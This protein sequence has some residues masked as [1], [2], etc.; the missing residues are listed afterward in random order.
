MATPDIVA[1]RAGQPDGGARHVLGPG[2]SSLGDAGQDA[3]M[4]SGDFLPCLHRQLGIEP[5]V[6]AIED[7]DRLV[8]GRESEIVRFGTLDP[9]L[10]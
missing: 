6:L 7:L 1:G 9:I 3:V 4:Q 10:A 5:N 8:P 2:P